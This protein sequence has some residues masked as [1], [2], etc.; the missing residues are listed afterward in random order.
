MSVSG[1]DFLILT[2]K[3][4]EELR[5]RTYKLDVKARNILFLID[6]GAKTADAVLQKTIFPREEVLERIS[7]LIDGLFVAI[8]GSG[9][10]AAAA[11]RGAANTT[12]TAAASSSHLSL[13]PDIS[14][15]E[16]RFSLSDFCL[17]HFGVR[18]QAMTDT[19]SRCDD[20]TSLQ[21][22]LNTIVSE[23]HKLCPDQLPALIARVREINETAI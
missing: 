18:G 21:A 4:S 7:A 2:A 16:G 9:A 17:D 12:P 19:L 1:K 23:V 3:G 11:N 14:L 15:T 20:V 22:A 8:A 10:P 6:K 5:T 13:L